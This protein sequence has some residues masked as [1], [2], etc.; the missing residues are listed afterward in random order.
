MSYPNR[1]IV[2]IVKGVGRLISFRF[3]PMRTPR[4]RSR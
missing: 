1:L 2:V 4:T 3:F